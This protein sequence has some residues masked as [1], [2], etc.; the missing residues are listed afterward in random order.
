LRLLLAG[1]WLAGDR[2]LRLAVF[3]IRSFF[4]SAD[5]ISS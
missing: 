2:D 5:A 1:D 3:R 4:E